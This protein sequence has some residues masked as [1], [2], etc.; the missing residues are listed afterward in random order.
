LGD[1]SREGS[2]PRYLLDEEYVLKFSGGST[3]HRLRNEA[4]V[5]ELLADEG[6]ELPVAELVDLDVGREALPYCVLMTT[7]VPGENAAEV[8][9]DLSE[10]NALMVA[11]QLALFLVAQHEIQLEHFGSLAPGPGEKNSTD[12]RGYLEQR[13]EHLLD[14]HMESEQ[15]DLELLIELEK[16]LP[17]LIEHLPV[18]E[19]SALVHGNL[20]LSAL[21]LARAGEE[22]RLVGISDYEWG[23]AAD[24]HFEFAGMFTGEQPELDAEAFWGAYW[25]AQGQAEAPP[26]FELAQECYRLLYHL[27]FANEAGRLG[28]AGEE[29]WRRHVAALRQ[30]LS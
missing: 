2:C 12:W 13:A 23:V 27:Q 24:P 19:K 8:W 29:A 30:A 10:E 25:Q 17:R 9:D 3:C 4:A 20:G 14:R 5:Y 16:E 26:G 7:A 22:W 18:P 11:R 21:K 15:A 1:I 6:P 28:Q